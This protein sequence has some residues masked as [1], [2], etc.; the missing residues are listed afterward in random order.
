MNIYEQYG[1]LQELYAN[2][3]DKHAQ[4]VDVLRRLKSGDLTLEMVTVGDDNTW[5]FDRNLANTS[6]VEV[7]SE[8]VN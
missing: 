4:T 6:E 8:P 7:G 1:R 3:C 2:E 5:S